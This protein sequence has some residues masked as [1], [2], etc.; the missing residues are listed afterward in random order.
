MSKRDY[1]DI[2]EVSR[3]ASAGELK[4]AFKKKAM[5]YH[6]DRNPDNPEAAKKFKEA[7]EAY[8]VLSDSQKKSAYDQFGH[9]GVEGMGGGPN[10]NDININD[11]FGDIFGDV[12]GTRSQSRRQ[13]R[14]SDLQYNLDLSLKEAVLGTTK[15]I[16][17]PSHKTCQD[18]NG[19]GAA[20]GSSP[21]NCPNC[22]GAGQVRMQQ[23]F[24]SVQQTC[25]PCSGTGQV[26]KDKCRTCRGVGAVKENKT[27]SVN[28]PSGVDNGDKV[29]LSGEGEWMKGSKSGDLYVAIRVTNNYLFERDGRDLYIETPI[30]F[31]TSVIGGSI[32]IPTLENTISLKIPPNTQTGKV[33][34][35][36]GKG[37]SI[38]RDRRRGDIL[39]RVVVETPSNLDKKQIKLLDE[40][41]KSLNQSKNYP[42][43]D[44]FL[45][46][47]SKI[48]E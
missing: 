11:I 36:K 21:I 10:F 19:N 39:C 8:D 27:L 7:A 2:L 18:C 40:F 9:S 6:P 22:N 33:F 46:A 1:Y 34:R 42:G 23:G 20:K 17:I 35:I 44:T 4:K 15:K 32:K 28:I 3:N 45:E 24:F 12:F 25:S 37:A 31:E 38:V 41:T 47:V 30:P 26:I 29:R 16:K 14:G 13:R 5:K 43:T 48:K